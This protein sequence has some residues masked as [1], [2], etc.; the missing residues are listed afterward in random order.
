MLVAFGISQNIADN[1]HKE[2]NF[3]D[4]MFN[5]ERRL[6][7]PKGG[8]LEFGDNETIAR[9]AA[10]YNRAPATMTQQVAMLRKHH[11]IHKRLKRFL[12]GEHLHT[13]SNRT[14]RLSK[15]QAFNPE[16][17]TVSALHD[18]MQWDYG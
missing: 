15:Q 2:P 18:I 4:Q 13:W 1:K 10:L 9:Y 6:R 5:L 3:C 14:K 17:H 12:L 8:L 16:V 11:K 7:D